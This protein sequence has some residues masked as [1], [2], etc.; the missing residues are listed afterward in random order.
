MKTQDSVRQILRTQTQPLHAALDR[1]VL[2]SAPFSSLATYHT[3]LFQMRQLHLSLHL[4]TQ[5]VSKRIDLPD[6][7]RQLIDAA[8]RDVPTMPKPLPLQRLKHLRNGDWGY[9][10][11]VEGSAFG[12][13]QMLGLARQRLP[14]G[15]STE[16]LNLMSASISTRWP[17]FVQ[18][19]EQHCSDIESAVAAAKH[20]FVI[21]HTIFGVSNTS[22]TTTAKSIIE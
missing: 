20:A 16:Y 1:H 21:A 14:H 11:V 19:L 18:A 7:G 17:I 2:A 9:A 12:A 3:F 6:S 5:A 8:T 13:A 10:Y 22:S 15:T 4:A